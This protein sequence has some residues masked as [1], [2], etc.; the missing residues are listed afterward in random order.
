MSIP[1]DPTWGQI[2]AGFLSSART[3][4]DAESQADAAEEKARLSVQLAKAQRQQSRDARTELE[5]WLNA[6][7]RKALQEAGT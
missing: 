3:A 4:R 7:K 1:S 6:A 2:Q 5:Q